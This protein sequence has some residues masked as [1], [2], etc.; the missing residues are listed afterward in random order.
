MEIKLTLGQVVFGIIQFI[1]YAAIFFTLAFRMGKKLNSMESHMTNT[2]DRLNDT[3][4]SVE[5]I[6]DKMERSLEKV[7]DDLRGRNNPRGRQ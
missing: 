1:G 2:T 5:K 6:A 3:I 7:W 4:K